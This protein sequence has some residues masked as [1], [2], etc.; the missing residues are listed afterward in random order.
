MTV[1]SSQFVEQTQ[2]NEY[3]GLGILTSKKTG[4]LTGRNVA[5]LNSLKGVK[6]M[7]VT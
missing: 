1:G 2:N 5:H 3:M 7:V 4:E 6:K